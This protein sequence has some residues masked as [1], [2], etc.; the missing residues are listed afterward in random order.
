MGAGGLLVALNHDQGLSS[1]YMHLDDYTVVSGKKV[2]DLIGH[3]G[4]S[5]MRE[6][7][8]HLHFELRR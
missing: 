2:N 1:H 6:S 5:G 7:S 3:V 8:A 4:R